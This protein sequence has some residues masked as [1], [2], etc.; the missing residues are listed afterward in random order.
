MAEI[1]S[2]VK[3]SGAIVTPIWSGNK[4]SRMYDRFKD[5]K[6]IGECW[7]TSAEK[8]AP[9]SVILDDHSILFL[10]Y[11]RTHD[12]SVPPLIKLIDAGESL[13]IQVHPD[14]IAAAVHGG[15]SKSELWY[16]LAAEDNTSILYGTLPGVTAEDVCAAVTDGNIETLLCRIPVKKG[17]IFM[18]PPGMIHSLGAGV[19]VLEIQDRAGTT[20]RIKDLSGNR[21]VHINESIDSIRI[22]SLD[23]AASLAFGRS[24]QPNGSTLPGTLIASL[25]GFSLT[26]YESHENTET[27]TLP[28]RGVYMFCEHGSGIAGT[29]SFA[30]GDSLFFGDNECTINIDPFT[31][32]FFAT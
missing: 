8:T 19:T 26:R 3:L 15:I 4:L 1:K 23:E 20:Y 9:A 24:H 12:L 27:L 6:K 7:E 21:E 2:P 28:D 5:Q 31:S 18:I 10:E 14:D 11:L 22:Y 25:P 32:V 17:D 29:V 13:S 30:S 16:I